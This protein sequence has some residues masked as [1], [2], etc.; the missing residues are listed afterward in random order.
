MIHWLD[1]QTES[2]C[3]SHLSD[4]LKGHLEFKAAKILSSH[5]SFR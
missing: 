5:V 3:R 4:F 2:F 1:A